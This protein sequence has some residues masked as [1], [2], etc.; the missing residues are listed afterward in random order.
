M[1]LHP[2][3]SHHP[4]RAGL[5]ATQLREHHNPALP[6]LDLLPISLPNTNPR[7]SNVPHPTNRHEPHLDLLLTPRRNGKSNA[8]WS[9]PDEMLARLAANDAPHALGRMRITHSQREHERVVQADAGWRLRFGGE[10]G[11]GLRCMDRREGDDGRYV[12]LAWDGG[13]AR[14]RGEEGIVV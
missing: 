2:R 6:N 8:A 12:C 3:L 9:S 1:H 13:G 11:F 10:E 14:G 4:R 7:P 5:I